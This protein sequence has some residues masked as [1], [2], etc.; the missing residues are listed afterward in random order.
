MATFGSGSRIPRPRPVATKSRVI[1]VSGVARNSP[2][3]LHL[4]SH[5]VAGVRVEFGPGGPVVA[6]TEPQGG[7]FG[8]WTASGRLAPSTPDD[9]DVVLTATA[10]GTIVIQVD[11]DKGVPFAEPRFVTVHLEP[12]PPELTITD[13]YPNDV[14]PASL[15]CQATIS[16]TTSGVLSRISEMRFAVEGGSSGP[17]QNDLRGLVPAARAVPADRDAQLS[18]HRHGQRRT[19]PEGDED[20]RHL[21][22]GAVR[23]HRSGAARILD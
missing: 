13:G 22:A 23:E 2:L 14:T 18:I 12:H 17:A 11:P 19:R 3:P 16:G 1:T 9:S 20:R 5:Q 4:P 6:A 21:D 10:F 8:T 7:A 15:P